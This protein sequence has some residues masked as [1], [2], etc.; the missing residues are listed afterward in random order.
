VHP[1]RLAFLLHPD[2]AASSRSV[3]ADGV[4][5]WQTPHQHCRTGEDTAMA[6]KKDKKKDKKK[7]GKKK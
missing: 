2:G 7:K 3:D 4:N 6:K 1:R 5:C